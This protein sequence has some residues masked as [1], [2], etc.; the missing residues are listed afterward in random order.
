MLIVIVIARL[1]FVNL[2]VDFNLSLC[3]NLLKINAINVKNRGFYGKNLGK[4]HG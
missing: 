4:S 3:Y 1:K 2:F